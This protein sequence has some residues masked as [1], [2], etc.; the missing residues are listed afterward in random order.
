MIRY[1]LMVSI[2]GLPLL[3]T[4]QLSPSR[5][6]RDRLGAFTDSNITPIFLWHPEGTLRGLT[7][8]W[9]RFWATNHLVSQLIRYDPLKTRRADHPTHSI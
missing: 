3:G 9:H 7:L 4:I 2:F 8:V 5:R 6:W 1:L